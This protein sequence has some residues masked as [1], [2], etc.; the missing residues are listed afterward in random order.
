VSERQPYLL[1]LKHVVLSE[2]SLE[3]EEAAGGPI[4]FGL[5]E[6]FFMECDVT[7]RAAR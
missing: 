2:R 3:G 7:C 5:K 4:R 1:N 6:I